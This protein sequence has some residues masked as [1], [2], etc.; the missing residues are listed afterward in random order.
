M[1]G[2]RDHAA[3]LLL[4]YDKA[5]VYVHEGLAERRAELADPRERAL[6]TELAYGT[7]RRLGTLDAILAGFSRRSLRDLNAYVR[8]ALRLGLYQAVFLDRVPSHASV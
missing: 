3:L 8:T 1:T 7:I 6:M 5:G 2:A 4:A